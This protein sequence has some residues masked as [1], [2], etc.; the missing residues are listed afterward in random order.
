MMTK[1]RYLLIAYGE[2]VEERHPTMQPARNNP[3]GRS[4]GNC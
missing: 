2:L 4:V 3:R 1:V